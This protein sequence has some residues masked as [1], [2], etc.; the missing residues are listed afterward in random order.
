MRRDRGVPVGVVIACMRSHP[1][2]GMKDFHGGRGEPGFQLLARQLVGNTVIMAVHLHVVID[3]GADG[4]PIRHS[5]G[6]DRQGLQ[7]RAIEF[8]KQAGA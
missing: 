4:L 7:G 3:R 2:A 6:L 8:G 5:V 1:F